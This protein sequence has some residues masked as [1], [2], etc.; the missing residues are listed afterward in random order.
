MS[1]R[2]GFRLGALIALTTLVRL[3]LAFAFPGF[4]AGDDVEILQAGFL[5][6][7]GW[8]YQPWEIRNLLIPDLLVAPVLRLAAALG[9]SST[10]TLVSVASVPFVLLASLN[11]W[12]VFLLGRRWLGSGRPALLAAVLY[13]LHWIPLG[14]GSTVYP[15]TASTACIL[16]AALLLSGEGGGFWRE[17]LAGGLVAVAFAERYSEGIF[18]LPLAIVAGL[19]K[20]EPRVRMVRGAAVLG[21]FLAAALLT[22]GLEEWLTWGKPFASLTA[23]AR[24]TMIERRSSSLVA[25]Q[26]WYWYAWRLP[27][28]LP[29][30]LLPFLVCARR[31][32]AALPAAVCAFLPLLL[33]SGVYHKE[34]RYLQGI[35]PFVFLTAAAGAWFLW[36]NGRRTATAALC[37]LSVALGFKGINF[38]AQKSMPAV[39]AAQA[40]AEAAR[41]QTVA[42]VQPWAFGGTLYLHPGIRVVEIPYPPTAPD[43]ESAAARARWIAVYRKD[44]APDLASVLDRRGFMPAGDFAWGAGRP[45]ALFTA[46]R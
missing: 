15:R 12:L 40:L 28:W 42:L 34:L 17:G 20:E 41:G 30:T 25:A 6:A 2:T 7:F 11:V 1:H 16:L 4:V 18:L 23:F 13:A 27:K 38:L 21:G 46:G 39:Q 44:L 26:P 3:A 43:L 35:L 10:Q 5:R 19:R 37:L 33:L 22:S 36:E 8:P 32:R 29:V 45:V 24:F 14:Y 31:V 9:I